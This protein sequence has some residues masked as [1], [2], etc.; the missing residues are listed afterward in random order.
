MCYLSQLNTIK[1]KSKVDKDHSFKT[2]TNTRLI[3]LIYLYFSWYGLFGRAGTGV[4]SRHHKSPVIGA[5]VAHDCSTAV[6]PWCTEGLLQALIISL[7]SAMTRDW[8][9]YTLCTSVLKTRHVS[10]QTDK[11][12]GRCGRWTP[13]TRVCSQWFPGCSGISNCGCVLM[14]NCNP[15]SATHWQKLAWFVKWHGNESS[16]SL[17]KL[18]LCL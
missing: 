11:V 1:I 15:Y 12:R 13:D 7:Q 2:K 4:D 16:L 17:Q 18:S 3:N 8:R 10:H 5:C 9:V 14:S 6:W